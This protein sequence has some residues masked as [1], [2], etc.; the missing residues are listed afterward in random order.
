MLPVTVVC[1][2][3]GGGGGGEMLTFSTEPWGVMSSSSFDITE[4]TDDEATEVVLKV[5][6]LLQVE[7]CDIIEDD[8]L[9]GGGGGGFAL[10]QLEL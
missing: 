5:E 2:Q 6:V 9:M 1:G 7:S 3:G 8:L 10:L 4:A